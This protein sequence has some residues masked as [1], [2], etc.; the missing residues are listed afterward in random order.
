MRSKAYPRD[1]ARR[2]RSDDTPL[3]KDLR[4]HLR[5]GVR[6]PRPEGVPNRGSHSD[7]FRSG[8][9]GRAQYDPRKG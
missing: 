4:A 5:D 8:W 3:Q 6:N 7:R 2:D 1:D 9:T